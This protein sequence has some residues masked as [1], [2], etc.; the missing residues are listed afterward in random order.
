[1][2]IAVGVNTKT[3]SE[4]VTNNILAG[5][6]LGLLTVG[7]LGVMVMT[8]EYSSGMIRATLAAA[9]DRPRLLAAKA[10]VFGAVALAMGEVASFISF[11][12]GGLAL[13][14]G[15]HAP[16]LSQPG[17]LRAVLLTGAGYCLVGLMG[18]GI[19]AAIRNSPA[20]I[21]VLVGGVY[22]AG[23][24]LREPFTLR[25][26]QEALY[27]LISAPLGIISFVITLYLLVPGLV[28][29]GTVL[30]TVVGLLVVILAMRAARALGG[31][32][33][34]LAARLLGDRL[35]GPPP[36]QRGQGILGRLDARLKDGTGWRAVAY[37][38]VK[39]P[40]SLLQF[41]ALAFWVNGVINLSYPLWWPL[42]RNAPPGT[43]L[44][45]RQVERDLHDGAQARL[46][47]MALNLG[48][49]KEKLGPEGDP[50]D[51]ARARGTHRR[52]PP[53][54]QGGPGRA[55]G[56][57]PG[58]PPAGP[59]QR[60]GRR[61]RDPGRGQSHPGAGGGGRPGPADARDR[62]DRLLLRGRAPGQ[63]DQAQR[64]EQDRDQGRNR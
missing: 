35:A 42:F 29:S 58:H 12:A 46:A 5:V 24:L 60:P 33:R 54:G 36:F 28:V 13:R 10:A 61:A 7:V 27:C 6:A 64:G 56:T 50:P 62:D 59:G 2:A 47:A 44:L 31:L 25:A 45:L 8:G 14:H 38:L 55:A 15:L 21:A 16:A 23:Q 40:V 18:L 39:F 37:M 26:R 30:G 19:G 1:M 34:R 17:V 11:F 49:A 52:R 63:R 48:M 22:V 41:Y 57:G 32:H 4:D 3:A 20:A 51:M 43:R 9:P 53:R